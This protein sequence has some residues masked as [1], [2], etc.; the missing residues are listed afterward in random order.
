MLPPAPARLR[1]ARK[2]LERGKGGKV[3]AADFVLFFTRFKLH[4]LKSNRLNMTLWNAPGGVLVLF[5][6]LFT[7]S[8]KKPPL[9]SFCITLAVQAQLAIAIL[10]P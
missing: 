3:A 7:P 10:G 9:C 8:S 2:S 5:A 1:D 6:L 4:C